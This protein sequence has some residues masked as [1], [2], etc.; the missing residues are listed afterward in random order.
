MI[1]FPED[2]DY[3]FSI[4]VVAHNHQNP[5]LK[6]PLVFSDLHGIPYAQGIP[7]RKNKFH[8]YLIKAALLNTVQEPGHWPFPYRV[9]PENGTELGY[10]GSH[11]GKTQRLCYLPP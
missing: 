2:P 9:F 3:I 4:H 7:G 1:T 6:D 11:E 5:I 10:L 8:D